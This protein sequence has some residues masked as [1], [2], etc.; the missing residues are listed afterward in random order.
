[1]RLVSFQSKGQR[2]RVGLRDYT[3][4]THYID[5][6]RHQVAVERG[7]PLLSGVAD[8]GRHFWQFENQTPKGLVAVLPIGRDIG[9]EIVHVLHNFRL[10]LDAVGIL[11]VGIRSRTL[12]LAV[13]IMIIDDR[14]GTG[15]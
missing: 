3:R 6:V 9:F 13:A 14:R 15:R 12:R 1:M 10:S 8:N 2:G 11:G 5:D 7:V 4:V